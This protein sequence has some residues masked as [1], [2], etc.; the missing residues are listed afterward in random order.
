MQMNGQTSTLTTPSMP[1]PMML[2]AALTLTAT[3]TTRPT[4]TENI[5]GSHPCHPRHPRD[6]TAMLMTPQAEPLT[7]KKLLSKEYALSSKGE[8]VALDYQ[9]KDAPNSTQKHAPSSSIM[10]I[11][12]LGAA[13]KAT[14]AKSST[15]EC[16]S[17]HFG[18]ENV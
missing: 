2:G 6:E 5:I 9:G 7:P 10:E 1:Y 16:A 8:H 15:L 11:A 3:Q 12:G 13:P 4:L 18:L 17:S 14:T